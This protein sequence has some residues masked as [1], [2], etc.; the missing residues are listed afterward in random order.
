MTDEFD[1]LKAPTARM[2]ARL[3]TLN[4]LMTKLETRY[5]AETRINE[6]TLLKSDLENAK[7]TYSQVLSEYQSLVGGSTGSP[8]TE[9]I[10]AN[11]QLQNIDQ[12]LDIMVME[13]RFIAMV[14]ARLS[15]QQRSDTDAVL[16]GIQQNT[17]PDEDLQQTFSDIRAAFNALHID[18]KLI[19][20]PLADP[21]TN[22]IAIF[23]DTKLDVKHKL[24]VT[25]PLIPFMLSYE[26]E[27]GVD[28]STNLSAVWEKLT[29]KLRAK[30][31]PANPT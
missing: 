23:E 7:Q 31:Q 14:I 26:T 15:I 22:A 30:N 24:K 28:G 2:V 6:R 3:K 19:A 11:I 16:A 1:P 27:I 9:L 25:I 20:S 4:D 8:S 13:Q 10:G 18:T 17:F 29:S 5:D 21:V 12:K